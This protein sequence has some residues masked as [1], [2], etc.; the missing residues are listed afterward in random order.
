[1]QYHIIDSDFLLRTITKKDNLFNGNYCIDPYH[2]CEFG[3]RYCDSSFEKEIYIKKNAVTILEKELQ[4]K[5]KGTIIIGSVHDPYQAAEE[6]YHLTK[7]ILMLLKKYEFACHILTKSTLILRDIDIL[8]S[9]NS[10]ATV[11]IISLKK[12]KTDLFE[13]E[14]I[15]SPQSRLHLVKT[16]NE[17]SI[18][19]GVALLPII[20]YITDDELENIIRETKKHKARYLLHKYLELKGEQKNKVCHL[21]QQHYPTVLHNFNQLYK[22]TI[23]PKKEYIKTIDKTI[24]R[25]CKQYTL[26]EK[27]R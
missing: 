9:M 1:M 5:A 20:P 13:H 11:S 14:N 27:I 19:T 25:H 17:H 6:R 22:N 10:R 23:Q 26:S 3:C 12:E 8:A 7:D 16:L 4:D 18:K 15:T 24:T 2:H 21:L